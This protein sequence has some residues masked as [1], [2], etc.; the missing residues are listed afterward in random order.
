MNGKLRRRY[1]SPGALSKSIGGNVCDGKGGRE[2]TIVVTACRSRRAA[3][4]QWRELESVG[5]KGSAGRC[6]NELLDTCPPRG[7]CGPEAGS[8][9]RCHR[10]NA[11]VISP[12]KGSGWS[13]L[14]SGRFLATGMKLLFSQLR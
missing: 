14:G 9:T 12:K 2:V 11:G 13:S 5:G 1:R 4:Q 3:S 10:Q 8:A 6:C 7:Y